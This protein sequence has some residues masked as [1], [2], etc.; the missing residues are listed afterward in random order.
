MVSIEK[1]VTIKR[2]MILYIG[3]GYSQYT[4]DMCDD[5]D[6]IFIT[7][8]ISYQWRSVLRCGERIFC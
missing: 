8:K 2:G 7:C 6:L 4:V 5:S 1:L 3:V